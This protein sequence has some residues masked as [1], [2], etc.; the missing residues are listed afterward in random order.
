MH[1]SRLLRGLDMTTPSR[2]ADRGGT[3]LVCG[4]SELKPGSR[5]F[6]SAACARRHYT[7]SGKP[8]NA[9]CSLC[10]Q[11]IDLLTPG[12]AR[13]GGK[14][15]RRRRRDAAFCDTCAG[16]KALRHKT[17][18]LVVAAHSGTDCGICGLPVDMSIKFPDRQSPTV[19]HIVSVA[20]GG[21]D[22]LENLQI[23]HYGCNSTKSRRSFW[24]Q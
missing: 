16:R 14:S 18:R 9:S 10:G 20:H 22:D 21:T 11:T 3:C 24:T 2:W 1:Y 19:D 8:L 17:S 6:C 12:K 13:N 23:A 15:T 7:N 5:K 4:S